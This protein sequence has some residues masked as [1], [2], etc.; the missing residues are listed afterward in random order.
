MNF[1]RDLRL[2]PIALIASAC[3]LTLKTAD[4]VLNG[5]DLF[6]RNRAPRG[7][8]VS[9]SRPAP[10][11]TNAPGTSGSWAAQMFNFPGGN[12]SG[13]L[14]PRES[15]RR[16][17]LPRIA[18]R[19]LADVTGSISTSPSS[20][21]PAAD[22]GSQ[23]AP[24]PGVIVADGRPVPTGAERAILERLQQRREELDARAHELDLR[25]S[26]I[27]GAE[28]RIEARLGELKEI[29]GR[30]KSETDQKEQAEVTRLKDLVSMY[31]NM[32]PRDAAKIFDGLEMDVLVSVTSQINPRQMSEILAQM[33]PAVA[34]HLTVELA[35]RAR[36]ARQGA[37]IAELPKIEG[38]PNGR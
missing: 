11:A 15:L 8:E 29:E 25:E 36:Q 18:A 1:V 32:K 34:E 4:L 27:E 17:D 10:D 35:N 7:G 26:L 3:L 9:V 16:E 30:I 28:K 6:A 14:P 19:D 22:T 31:Q 2:I 37:G 38:A 23:A 33:T 5:S 24:K 20:G 12:A 21:A 13:S